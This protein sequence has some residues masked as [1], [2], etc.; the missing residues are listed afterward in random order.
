LKTNERVAA[1]GK[2]LIKKSVVAVYETETFGSFLKDVLHPGGLELTRRA[3]KTAQIDE[4]CTVLDIACGKGESIFLLVK[5]FGCCAVGID[6]SLPKIVRAATG[7][8]ERN[9]GKGFSFL[10]SDA[11]V[12]PFADAVFDVVLSECSFSVLPSK[13]RA[14]SE[15]A[16]VLKS[17]GRFVMTDIVLGTGSIGSASDGLTAGTGLTL[18]CIAGAQSVAD[19]IEILRESG[20]YDAYVEDHSKELKKIAYQMA[21]SFGGWKEFLQVLSSELCHRSSEKEEA[22][23]LCYIE[24]H[25]KAA[26]SGRPGYALIRVTKS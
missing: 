13:G 26:A 24:P 4:G 18:P 17:G 22:E 2:H 19:Y 20:L 14:A 10:V 5:E 9:L 7:A 1:E 16:R 8:T 25:R 21:L 6:L 11:E 15:I 23:N 3:G 12:L